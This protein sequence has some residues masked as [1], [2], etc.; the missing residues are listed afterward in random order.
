[1]ESLYVQVLDN[2]HKILPTFK[3]HENKNICV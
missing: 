3:Q 1:M 2:D